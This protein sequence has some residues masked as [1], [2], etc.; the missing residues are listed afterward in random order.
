MYQETNCTIPYKR[1]IK[2]NQ[3]HHNEGKEE[4][5][6]TKAS[7]SFHDNYGRTQIYKSSGWQ[8]Q[9]IKGVQVTVVQYKSTI[10]LFAK[11]G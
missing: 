10:S 6:L 1:K 7:P 9:K 5:N 11:N 4:L 2:A 8:S 3:I